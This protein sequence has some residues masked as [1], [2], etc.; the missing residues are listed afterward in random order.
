M[1]LS[2]MLKSQEVQ[3]YNE[4][5]TAV[6]SGGVLQYFVDKLYRLGASKRYPPTG[7]QNRVQKHISLHP[8]NGSFES[9][10]PISLLGST[11]EQGTF[12][13]QSVLLWSVGTWELFDCTTLLF[14]FCGF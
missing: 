12:R 6:Q 13:A 8:G 3:R 2:S 4:E 10:N 7:G 9:E 14:Q 5:R 1:S 11:G